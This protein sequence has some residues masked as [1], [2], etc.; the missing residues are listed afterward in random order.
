MAPNG[1][2]GQE[3]RSQVPY[4]GYVSR[5]ARI[6]WIAA[7]VALLAAATAAAST[8]PALTV[9]RRAPLTIGGAGFGAREPLRVTATAGDTTWRTA[10]LAGAR[11]GFVVSWP[12]ARWEPCS[13]PL[14]LVARG[15]KSG[16]V[17]RKLPLEECA[18]Q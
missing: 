4:D 12:A 16:T 1:L 3:A 14:L 6:A 13:T 9:V 17:T 11:G 18:P 10:V 2:T 5:M 7:A 8:H 15:P